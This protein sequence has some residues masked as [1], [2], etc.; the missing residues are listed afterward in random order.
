MQPLIPDSIKYALPAKPER[1]HLVTQ[2]EWAASLNALGLKYPVRPLDASLL[3]PS[4]F[5]PAVGPQSDV[6]F[7]VARSKFGNLPIYRTHRNGGT[8]VFTT[9]R[10]VV[11]DQEA[12]LQELTLVLSAAQPLEKPPVIERCISGV[13]QIQ[14]DYMPHLLRWLKG[15]GF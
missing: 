9:V 1:V 13:F 8:R 7:A 5:S 15:L 11:G 6:P 2:P 3:T 10:H 4:G 12:F 14:G